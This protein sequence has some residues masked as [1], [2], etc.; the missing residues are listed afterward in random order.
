MESENKIVS[1]KSEIRVMKRSEPLLSICIPT[2]NRKCLVFALVKKLLSFSGD[3]EICV[4]VDGSSDNTFQSLC[5]LNDVRLR[6]RL[7][8]NRGRAGA[9][10]SAVDCSN[11]RFCMVFDD[12]DEL[13]ASG[14]YKILRDCSIPLPDECA[15]RVYH[16]ADPCGERIGSSFPVKRTSLTALR[17]DYRVYGDKKEVIRADLLKQVVIVQP[18]F[19]RVPTSLYW[20]RISMAYDIVCVNDVVGT[21][22]YL[23]GGMSRSVRQLIRENAYPMIMLHRTILKLFL[24]G[25]IKSRK[26]ALRALFAILIYSLFS[27]PRITKKKDL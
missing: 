3:F 12:D 13:D 8:E 23:Q 5:E 11:G 17:A 16:L 9:L 2:Y 15:G 7:S 4:H 10:R 24:K 27:F 6:V 18:K 25:R 21:K 14:L 20:A 19:R 1:K 22:Q 26:Y